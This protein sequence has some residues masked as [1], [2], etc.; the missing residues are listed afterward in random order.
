[1]RAYSIVASK[2]TGETAIFM[3][4]DEE[5]GVAEGSAVPEGMGAPT[6]ASAEPANNSKETADGGNAVEG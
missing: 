4:I 3:D 5:G 2:L 6:A 1:M